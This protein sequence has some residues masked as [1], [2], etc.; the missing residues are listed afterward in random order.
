MHY[1]IVATKTNQDDSHWLIPLSIRDWRSQPA[2]ISAFHVT[3]LMTISRN[4]SRTSVSHVCK[5]HL[6][7]IGSSGFG[8]KNN[9]TSL[10][11]FWVRDSLR[12]HI[13][14][15]LN[16][17]WQAGSE[18]KSNERRVFLFSCGCLDIACLTGCKKL[19]LF[20]GLVIF[21]CCLATNTNLPFMT[22]KL[23]CSWV[24]IALKSIFWLKYE[25][26]TALL[27]FWNRRADEMTFYYRRKLSIFFC[28]PTSNWSLNV[29]CYTPLAKYKI[30]CSSTHPTCG[31][32]RIMIPYWFNFLTSLAMKRCTVQKRN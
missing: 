10:V 30:G 15:S 25:D 20:F 26:V 7:F 29:F 4:L 21:N 13:T 18:M 31:S 9:Q 22:G 32:V 3:S 27:R 14:L 17:R 6:G 28:L 23:N 2:M 5:Y 12:W 19:S 1:W 8:W 16:V 11:T 24:R